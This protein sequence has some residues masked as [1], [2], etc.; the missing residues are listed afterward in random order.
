MTNSKKIEKFVQ[1]TRS[2]A[3]WSSELL[4]VIDKPEEK[5]PKKERELKEKI[6]RGEGN[7]RC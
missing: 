6:K 1:A 7:E 4:K 2:L 3:Y 5:V